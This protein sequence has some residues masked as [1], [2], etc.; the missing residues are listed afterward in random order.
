MI[1]H[2]FSKEVH[3]HV[4]DADIASF[5]DYARVV[6]GLAAKR[7]IASGLPEMCSHDV[8][9]L[10]EFELAKPHSSP[11]AASDSALVSCDCLH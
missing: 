4:A 9:I 3:A 11:G 10:A 7:A 6:F 8:A 5:D 1:G 2:E